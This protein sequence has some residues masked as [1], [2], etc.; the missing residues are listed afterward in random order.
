[1]KDIVLAPI[2]LMRKPRLKNIQQTTWSPPATNC[3]DENLVQVFRLWIFYSF[4]YII[5]PPNSAKYILI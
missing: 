4:H 2:F 5:L 1:M 3:T